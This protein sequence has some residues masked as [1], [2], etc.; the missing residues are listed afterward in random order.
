MFQGRVRFAIIDVRPGYI[1]SVVDAHGISTVESAFL[2]HYLEYHRPEYVT[3]SRHCHMPT[4]TSLFCR[5]FGLIRSDCVIGHFV[6]GRVAQAVILDE[7]VQP[8]LF[9]TTRT[10]ILTVHWHRLLIICSLQPGFQQSQL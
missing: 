6:L 9:S 10:S 8:G 3:V 7:F 1:Q 5:A 2:Q 4:L